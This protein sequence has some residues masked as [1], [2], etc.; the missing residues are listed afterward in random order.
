[1]TILLRLIPLLVKKL[2]LKDEDNRLLAIL[3]TLSPSMKS[4]SIKE[5]Y[6]KKK[7]CLILAL[8]LMML[9]C[10]SAFLMTSVSAEDERS[11][12]DIYKMNFASF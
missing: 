12:Y 8:I 5:C 6:M 3:K 7:G 9:P 1:M 11:T 2:Y 10:L 4:N